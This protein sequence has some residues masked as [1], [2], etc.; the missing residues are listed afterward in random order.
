MWD[1]SIMQ[2]VPGIRIAAPRDEPTLREALR[3]AVAVDDGPTVVRF[4]KGPVGADIPAIERRGVVDV[5]RRETGDAVLLVAVGAMVRTA[6]E[7]AERCAAHGIGVSVVDPRWVTP[8]PPEL[9]ALAAGYDLVVTL[10]DNGRSGGVGMTV[11][12]ALRDAGVDVPAR[13]LGIPR[14]FLDHGTRAQVLAELGLTAQDVA[15]QVVELVARLEPST[16]SS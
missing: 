8:V 12:Q 1:L 11:S 16:I 9:V 14:T 2:L 7:V 13:D 15:R 4:S 5:V 6:L 10:E 3:E